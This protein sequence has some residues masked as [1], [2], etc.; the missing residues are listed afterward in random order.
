MNQL[1]PSC[2]ADIIQG[3]VPCLDGLELA[4]AL[5]WAFANSPEVDGLSGRDALVLMIDQLHELV[6]IGQIVLPE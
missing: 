6:E 4:Q 1:T 3:L 2:T 5:L